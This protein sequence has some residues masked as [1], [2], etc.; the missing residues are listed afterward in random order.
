MEKFTK[1]QTKSILKKI[2]KMKMEIGEKFI[3]NN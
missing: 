2:N 3:K 1:K